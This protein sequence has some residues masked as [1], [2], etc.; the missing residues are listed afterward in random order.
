MKQ[1]FL[2]PAKLNPR[3]VRTLQFLRM[4]LM[5]RPSGNFPPEL[6]KRAVCLRGQGGAGRTCVGVG[7]ETD[8]LQTEIG[9]RSWRAPPISPS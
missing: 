8:S 3:Q 1:Q 6:Q 4:E 5:G 9:L 2:A 7:N